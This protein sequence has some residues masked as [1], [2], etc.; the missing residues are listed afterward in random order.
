VVHA[1][2]AS[3]SGLVAVGVNLVAYALGASLVIERVFEIRGLGALV[4][5]ASAR[6]DAP[7]VV[8]ATVCAGVVLALVS[9]A[10]DFGQRALD[11]RLRAGEEGGV[12]A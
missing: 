1:L 11:P 8:G 12:G 10:A 4:L 3:L 9:I 7:V 6:G 5:D 2:G